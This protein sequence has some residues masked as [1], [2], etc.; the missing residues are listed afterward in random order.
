M[1]LFR[2]LIFNNR[3][4]TTFQTK[5]IFNSNT[6]ITQIIWIDYAI[7]VSEIFST[8]LNILL[9]ILSG[10]LHY[11]DGNGIGDSLYE[12][13]L[14]TAANALCFF[15]TFAFSAHKGGLLIREFAKLMPV[16]SRFIEPFYQSRQMILSL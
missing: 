3:F 12:M 7:L 13:I 10:L 1:T 4:A 14:K 16:P 9:F 2:L 5:Y 15:N 11:F 8:I 6:Y